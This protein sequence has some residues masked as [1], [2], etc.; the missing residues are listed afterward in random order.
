[1][2]TLFVAASNFNYL[3]WKLM[4]PRVTICDGCCCGRVEKGNK[5]SVEYPRTAWKE[6]DSKK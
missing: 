5:D 3:G 2:T 1:M 4:A 6:N